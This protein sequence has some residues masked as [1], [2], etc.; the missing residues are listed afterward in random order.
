MAQSDKVLTLRHARGRARACYPLTTLYGGGW[1][2]FKADPETGRP[3]GELCRK[4]KRHIHYLE[5]VRDAAPAT[6]AAKQWAANRL[7]SIEY[8][9]TRQLTGEL[10]RAEKELEFATSVPSADGGTPHMHKQVVT[11]LTDSRTMSASQRAAA[12]AVCSHKA[13]REDGPVG[14]A[15]TCER[16]E[17]RDAAIKALNKA[18][19][20]LAY[21]EY[22][23]G[24][25]TQPR[26]VKYWT[27]KTTELAIAV[28][29]CETALATA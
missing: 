18:R 27:E 4:A 14:H 12:R 19:K 15:R 16:A 10:C 7:D 11:H 28:S 17:K 20:D 13:A 9:I 21:A 5:W 22:K 3:T 26:Y 1:A 24:A 29:E 6:I 2:L 8:D 25:A 23:R